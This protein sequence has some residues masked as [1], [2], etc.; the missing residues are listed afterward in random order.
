M[1]ISGISCKYNFVPLHKEFRLI[2][3]RKPVSETDISNNCKVQ[4]WSTTDF[5][6]ES[7]TFQKIYGLGKVKLKIK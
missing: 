5:V 7:C 3:N 1:L 2:V 4:H 6:E